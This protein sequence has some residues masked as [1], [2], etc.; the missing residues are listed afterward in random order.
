MPWQ[1]KYPE[2]SSVKVEEEKYTI[3]D[4]V[5]AKIR[6]VSYTPAKQ[7]EVEAA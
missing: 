3:I 2:G 4:G 5:L 1:P 7:S 6:V